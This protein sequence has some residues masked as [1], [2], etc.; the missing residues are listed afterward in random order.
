L[1]ENSFQRRSNRGREFGGHIVDIFSRYNAY[2]ETARQS[3]EDS[4]TYHPLSEALKGREFKF[5]EE[6]EQEVAPGHLRQEHDEVYQ[7]H[8]EYCNSLMCEKSTAAEVDEHTI[9]NIA[10]EMAKLRKRDSSA[11]KQGGGNGYAD[12]KGCS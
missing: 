9:Y 11:A 10:S 8:S 4:P 2:V 5:V 3:R 12:R 6:N 1:K 7:Y